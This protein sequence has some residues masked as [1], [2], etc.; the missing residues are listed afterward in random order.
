MIIWELSFLE[1]I[2]CYKFPIADEEETFHKYEEEIFDNG[3]SGKAV[4]KELLLIKDEQKIDVDISEI[5]DINAIIVIKHI[6]YVEQSI[7]YC[8][9]DMMSESKREFKEKYES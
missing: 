4:W 6:E 7:K 9:M 5:K 3:L 2:T 8:K 1:D